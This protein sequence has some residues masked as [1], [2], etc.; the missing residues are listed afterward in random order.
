MAV[1]RATMFFKDVNGAGWS[2]T[3]YNTAANLTQAIAALGF[4]M[5]ARIAL[6]GTN[7]G[8]F[9]GRVSDDLVKRDSQILVNP[10]G[11][12]YPNRGS[13]SN[14]ASD[15]V[16][17]RIEGTNLV[18]PAFTV[19]RSLA[20][21]GTPVSITGAAGVFVG[22]AQWNNAFDNWVNTLVNG[23]W[24]IRYRDS[25]VPN[26]P[27][28]VV[29]QNLANG[30]VT[31]TT[32]IAHT[33]AFRD[34]VQIKGCLGATEING[35]WTVLTV[36]DNTHFTIQTNQIVGAY[37]GGGSVT[38]YPY[39]LARINSVQIIRCATHKAGRPFDQLRGR[40]RVRARR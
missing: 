7:S 1:I 19:R 4:L 20:L 39:A 5:P 36:A 3:I 6:C 28:A 9:Y 17:I 35:S 23:G 38:K 37:I 8:L 29:G 24:A 31:I 16:V 15:D 40:R 21:R 11:N 26:F 33:F 30:V 27:I 14:L 32:S 10:P 25:T 22:T 34:T 18:G 2:E 13:V 12:A